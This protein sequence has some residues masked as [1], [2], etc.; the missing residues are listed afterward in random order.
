[1]AFLSGGRLLVAACGAIALSVSAHARSAQSIE[2]EVKAAFLFNFTKFAEWPN[3]Q[4]HSAEPFR[5]CAAADAAF[6]RA[7]DATIQGETAFGRQLVLTTPATVE[8]A[9]QCQLLYIGQ[10]ERERGPR[11]LA[12]VRD[13]PVLTVSDAPRC[14]SRE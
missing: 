11:L 2:N 13:L 9:R 12:A 8:A 1:M 5:I 3:A 10:S 4:E 14:C 6:T 7:L